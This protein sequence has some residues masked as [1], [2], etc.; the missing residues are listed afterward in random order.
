MPNVYYAKTITNNL[1]G[2]CQY[3]IPK[4]FILQMFESFSAK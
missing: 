3:V 1:R 4:D 2:I